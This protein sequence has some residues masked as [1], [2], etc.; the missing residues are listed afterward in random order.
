MAEVAEVLA[1]IAITP[2]IVAA[3]VEEA[4]VRERRRPPGDTERDACPRRRARDNRCA[5]RGAL[6]NLLDGV[7]SSGG[8]RSEGRELDRERGTLER[9]VSALVSKPR[10]LS[11]QVEA[12]AL[13]RPRA[14]QSTSMPLMT[15]P[16]ARYS[17]EYFVTSSVE[18]GH[19]GSYQW[20]GPFGF[21]EK[22]ASG[23]FI[24][25]WSG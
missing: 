4:R 25:Q 17:Q 21:L 7:V 13:T 11:A 1:R 12:L 2:E 22:D 9:R 19:I 23:A 18:D 3:L 5:S 8:V 10:D 15:P 6:D 14:A 16:S 20:K 24:H